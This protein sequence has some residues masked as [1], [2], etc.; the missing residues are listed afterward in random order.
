MMLGLNPSRCKTVSIFWWV[1]AAGYSVA[2]KSATISSSLMALTVCMLVA[3]SSDNKRFSFSYSIMDLSLP[4]CNSILLIHYKL[5]IFTLL[6]H[7]SGACISGRN[8]L[9]P[10]FWGE[11]HFS[12]AFA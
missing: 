2:R 8:V 6:W 3:P 11:D 5:F 12:F 10:E 9:G 4:Q 1:R 7:T